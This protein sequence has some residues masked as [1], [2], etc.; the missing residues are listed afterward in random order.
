MSKKLFA[1]ISNLIDAAAIAGSALL[2]YFQPPM[3]AAWVGAIGIAKV[4][5]N[6]IM[7]LFVEDNATTKSKK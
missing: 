4:A 2:V 7:L 3:F 1:L 5:I 6:D